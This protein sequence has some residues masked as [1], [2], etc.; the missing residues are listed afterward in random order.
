MTNIFRKYKKIAK[1]MNNFNLK[2]YWQKILVWRDHDADKSAINP[3]RAWLVLVCFF[4]VGLVIVLSSLFWL[5]ARISN[6]E[7]SIIANSGAITEKLNE[8]KLKLILVDHTKRVEEFNKLELT[9]PSVI[10]PGV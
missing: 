2:Q 7:A 8:Q 4:F 6:Q 1:I 3:A 5:K 10:D 9:K